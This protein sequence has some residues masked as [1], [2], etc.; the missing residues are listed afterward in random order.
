MHFE[1]TE[2]DAKTFAGFLTVTAKTPAEVVQVAE[3]FDLFDKKTPEALIALADA[4]KAGTLTHVSK[5]TKRPWF[6]VESALDYE[7]TKPYLELLTKLTGYEGDLP[8][9]DLT[10]H[11]P[12]RLCHTYHTISCELEHGHYAYRVVTQSE[13]W[14]GKNAQEYADSSTQ[15]YVEEELG[16]RPH[17]PEHIE[18]RG[19]IIRNPNYLKRHR[20]KAGLGS[21]WLWAVL[22][23]W[24]L[25]KYGTQA[26]RELCEQN[27]ALMMKNHRG[28]P[29]WALRS[30]GH[31]P[32][33]PIGYGGLRRTWEAPL[34]TWEEFKTLG[35]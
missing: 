13:P 19:R 2:T 25:E 5:P 23:R 31:G 4:I 28:E 14:N 1:F 20:A 15:D 22:F 34:V 24:W 30:Y 3:H 21:P 16:W 35:K 32:C 29:D 6:L 26:Q 9:L 27:A 18:E 12:R 17:E 11:H 33:S 10:P 8:D 7:F